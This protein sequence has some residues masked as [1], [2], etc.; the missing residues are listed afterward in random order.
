MYF[1]SLHA[2]P[3]VRPGALCHTGHQAA[4]Q[5][6][7]MRGV[8]VFVC[9]CVGFVCRGVGCRSNGLCATASVL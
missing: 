9:L 6:Q 8:G 2:G 1:L 7:V 3:A 5:T 4:H